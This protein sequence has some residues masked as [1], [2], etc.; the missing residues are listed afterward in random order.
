MVEEVHFPRQE[1]DRFCQASSEPDAPQFLQ[2]MYEAKGLPGVGWKTKYYD[3]GRSYPP[4]PSGVL[5]KHLLLV[6]LG[7]QMQLHR[8]VCN[9][10][11]LYRPGTNDGETVLGYICLG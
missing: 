1:L 7:M 9:A 6:A 10:K 3:P 5:Y 8:T 11:Q 2:H 4:R